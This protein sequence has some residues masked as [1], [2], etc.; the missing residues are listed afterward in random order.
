MRRV[1]SLIRS[2]V[3]YCSVPNGVLEW[4]VGFVQVINCLG[5][6]DRL[7]IVPFSSKV[8]TVACRIVRATNRGATDLLCVL[9]HFAFC[10]LCHVYVGMR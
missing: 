7:S 9:K 3:N 8:C 4:F 10:V 2:N 6:N 5:P 1:S